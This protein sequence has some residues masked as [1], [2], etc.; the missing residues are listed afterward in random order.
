MV[1]LYWG[2]GAGSGTLGES[3]RRARGTETVSINPVPV[4]TLLPLLPGRSWAGPRALVVQ[5]TKVLY[6]GGE[7]LGAWEETVPAPHPDDS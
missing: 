7:H 2:V 4:Q 6:S 1:A 5:H 3:T